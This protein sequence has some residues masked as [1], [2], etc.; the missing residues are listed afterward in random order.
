MKSSLLIL[1]VAVF[2]DGTAHCDETKWKTAVTSQS[3]FVFESESCHENA[4][5]G[6]LGGNGLIL[7]INYERFF[8]RRFG[9]RVGYGIVGGAIPLMVNWYVGTKYQLELGAGVVFNPSWKTL[10]LTEESKG[11]LLLTSTVGF[12]FDA[13]P[14]GGF[15]VRASLTPF[16]NPENVRGRLIV[17][18]GLGSTF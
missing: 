5:F 14:C 15:F 12:K 2:A 4:A 18:L 13:P 1:C 9:F 17:G 16:F 7:S 6:E 3:D 11:P 10:T 8:S